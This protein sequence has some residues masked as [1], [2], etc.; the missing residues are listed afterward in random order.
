MVQ[1]DRPSSSTQTGNPL[2]EAEKQLVKWKSKLNRNQIDRIFKILDLFNIEVYSKEELE[3]DYDLLENPG[4]N[5]VFDRMKQDA[6]KNGPSNF[7]N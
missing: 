1:L 3:P 7:R 2:L 4:P 5:H 6:G